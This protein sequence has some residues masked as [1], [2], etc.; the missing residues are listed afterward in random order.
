[1]EWRSYYLD[2]ILVPLV[3]LMGVAY[4]CWLWHKVRT[5][6]FTTI[7]GTNASGQRLWVSSIMKITKPSQLPNQHS[8]SAAAAAAPYVH[9]PLRLRG[10][11]VA[12]GARL[13]HSRQPPLLCCR[14]SFA[15]DLWTAPSFLM[16]CHY[17]PT[18]LQP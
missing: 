1:M 13:Q 8:A 12:K 11:G 7:I 9:V 4:H 6:P 18:S 3:L 2:M 16:L 10:G 15:L 14:S 17:D 5:Q